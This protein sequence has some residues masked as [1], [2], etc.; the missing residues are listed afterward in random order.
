MIAAAEAIPTARRPRN[1]KFIPYTPLESAARERHVGEA[2]AV[3]AAI[4]L[5]RAENFMPNTGVS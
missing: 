5:A 3:N 4:A 1:L 2:G